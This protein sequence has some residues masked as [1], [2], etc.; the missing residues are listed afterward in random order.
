MFLTLL[1]AIFFELSITRTPDN[2]NF[3]RFPLKVR[4]IGSRL[5]IHSNISNEAGFGHRYWISLLRS[6]VVSQ[7]LLSWFF[8]PTTDRK[9]PSRMRSCSQ[10]QG[11]FSSLLA[12]S[13]CVWVLVAL[14]HIYKLVL[15]SQPKQLNLVSR[16]SQLRALTRSGL[17]F[18]RHFL[19]KHKILPNLVISYWLWWI[20]RVLLANQNWGNILNE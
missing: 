14:T 13:G 1:S 8:M 5:Y 17:H 19:V 3:F 9:I 12:M 15:F 7:Q 4:V 6:L 16:S 20:M 11:V 10:W 2:S 18:W